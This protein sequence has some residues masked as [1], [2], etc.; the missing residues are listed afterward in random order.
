VVLLGAALYNPL[1]TSSVKTSTDFA[2]ALIGF[3]LLV[4]WRTSPLIAFVVGALAGTTL[5][6]AAG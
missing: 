1:W 6:I 4:A 2:I 5:S 3:V